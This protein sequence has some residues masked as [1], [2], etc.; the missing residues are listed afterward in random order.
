MKMSFRVVAAIVLAVSLGVSTYG[1]FSFSSLGPGGAYNQNFDGLT[2]GTVPVQDNVSF[3]GVYS[4]RTLGDA[5][6]NLFVADTGASNAGEFKNYGLNLDTDRC[7]GS[8]ASNSTGDMFYGI[9]FQ[10]DTSTTIAALQITYTGEQWRTATSVPGTLTFSY[11]VSP[12][13]ITDLT[14]GTY[15]NFPALDFTTPTNT[16]PPGALNGNLPANRVTVTAVLPVSIP[17]LQEIMIRWTDINDASN[18]QGAGIDDV[19]VT[20]SATTTAADV[21]IGGRVRTADGRGIGRVTVLLSGGSL[22]EPMVA[23]TNPFGF[24]RFDGVPSGESYVLSVRSK[25]HRFENSSIF[26]NVGDEI[27]GLDFTAVP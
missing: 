9:R 1:Q 8:L 4:F 16:T 19:T 14:T 27:T 10:N 6:P 12:F 24:Y 18:D 21:S 7:F 11:R 15:T 5:P 23:L 22:A 17:P 25:R 3:L 13:D 2:T 26:I 20:A